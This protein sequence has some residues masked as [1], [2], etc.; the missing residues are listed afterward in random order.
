MT[1]QSD[2]LNKHVRK[3]TGYKFEGVVVAQFYSLAGKERFV[4]DNYDGMLHIFNRAQLEINPEKEQN[5][6]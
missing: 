3:V 6:V 2:L 5:L 4:V 1:T